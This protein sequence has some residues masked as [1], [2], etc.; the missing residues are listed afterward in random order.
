MTNKEVIQKLE[1]LKSAV[2]NKKGRLFFF[3]SDTA[4]APMSSVEQIYKMAALMQDEGYPVIIVHEKDKF[5][6][7]ES[8]M[9]ERYSSLKHI[10][11]S[12][13]NENTEYKITGADTFFVPELFSDLIKKLHE[14]KLPSDTVVIC[15]SHSFIFKYLNAGENWSY[16]GVDNV[17]TTS[18]KMKVFLQEYQPVKNIFVVN[19]AIP[20]YFSPSTFPQK[21]I[22]SIISRSQDD[23]ERAVKLF[24]QKYPMYSWITFRTLG[25]MKKEDCAEALKE[26]CLSVWIDDFATFGTFPLESMASGV[27]CIMKIPDLIP[28]WAE[29]FTEQGANLADNA[30]YVSNVLGLPDYIA[31][32]MEAWLLGD[33]PQNLYDSMQATPILYTEDNFVT[34]TKNAFSGIFESKISKIDN[35]IK[36]YQD[37]E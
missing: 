20:S 28:E 2:E 37:E 9:G 29:V 31:K 7:V 12:A 8:W 3:V 35:T 11:L 23:L 22:I 27:P 34:Q 24:Y 4:G 33:V 6:G 25:G 15:Q 5:V 14:T 13:M 32:F 18:N 21:P 10:P 17:I 19:P 36:K 1:E 30:I 26:T 16:Y